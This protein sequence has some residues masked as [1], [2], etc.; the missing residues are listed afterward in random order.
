MRLETS[1]LILRILRNIMLLK[2]NRKLTSDTVLT[3]VQI[4][5]KSSQNFM[6]VSIIC[7]HTL[8]KTPHYI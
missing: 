5:F 4:L 6:L 3:K 2:K 8:F 1:N 7:F